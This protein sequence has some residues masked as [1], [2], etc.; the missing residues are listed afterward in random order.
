M[1]IAIVGGGAAGAMLALNL[2]RQAPLRGS[3]ITIIEPST[4]LGAGVAYAP[5]RP[6][7]RLN[8]AASRMTVLEEE[9]EDFSHWLLAQPQL[10]T[11]GDRAADGSVFPP[12][13]L[14][15]QYLHER[16]ERA[17]QSTPRMHVEH[18]RDRAATIVPRAGGFLVE[19]RHGRAI[20]A[21]VLALCT[22]HPQV[23]L[24]PRLAALAGDHRVIAEPWSGH[25][26]TQIDRH[27][28]VLIV[29]TGLT[30]GDVVASL[31]AQGH[32]GPIMAVSRRGLLPRRRDPVNASELTIGIEG[33]P[34]SQ[35]LRVLRALMRA[36]QPLPWPDVLDA[37]RRSNGTIWQSWSTVERRRFL[38]HLR[39]YWDVHRFQAAPQIDAAVEAARDDGQLSVRAGTLVDARAGTALAVTFRPRGERRTER[40]EVDAVVNCTGTAYGTAIAGNGALASLAAAGAVRADPLGL[41]LDVDEL[42]RARRADG[43][44]NGALF[45]LGA[46]AR[47]GLGEVTGAS[48]IAVHARSVA[49]QIALARSALP[50][51]VTSADLRRHVAGT[52]S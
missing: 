35:M 25:A 11:D 3:H 48:E 42:G 40:L 50:E 19:T 33:L 20:P 14:F 36:E 22:G 49:R 9:P 51:R 41:G 6:E 23:G 18:L 10:V 15:G 16:L 21:D 39:P 38:R 32:A 12:R 4:T 2:L 1:S 30:M 8:V 37:L 28:R 46:P 45:V 13:S 29:G 26:L 7:H 47:G 24:P 34:L 43:T 27:A 52:V 5:S 31:R 44:C 17:A